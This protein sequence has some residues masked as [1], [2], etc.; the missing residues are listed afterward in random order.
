MILF[1]LE[2]GVIL[3]LILPTVRIID[4]ATEGRITERRITKR[5][6]T[7]TNN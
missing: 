3:R 1:K 6:I 4:C 7:T 2:D 5:R